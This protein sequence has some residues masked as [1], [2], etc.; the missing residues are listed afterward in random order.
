MIGD[1]ASLGQPLVT[2]WLT[3]FSVIY[4]VWLEAAVRLSTTLVYIISGSAA[5]IDGSVVGLVFSKNRRL[6][7]D[8]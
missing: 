1:D 5:L 3:D 7:I 8:S 2:N 6:F 4:I